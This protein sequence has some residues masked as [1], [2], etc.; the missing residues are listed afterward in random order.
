M[1]AE[2]RQRATDSGGRI[3][4]EAQKTEAEANGGALEEKSA[5]AGG[6]T[7]AE[8]KAC[9][10]RPSRKT[11]LLVTG[12]IALSLLL[13]LPVW[14]YSTRVY[15][16]P[17]PFAEISSFVHDVTARPISLSVH[18]DVILLLHPLPPT[19]QEEQQQQQQ[20]QS[21]PVPLDPPYPSS[22]LHA[23]AQAALS[24]LCSPHAVPDGSGFDSASHAA[25]CG[26]NH[27]MSVTLWSVKGA[28]CQSALATSPAATEMASPSSPQDWP[29]HLNWAQAMDAKA[30]LSESEFDTWLDGRIQGALFPSNSSGSSSPSAHPPPWDPVRRTQ[31]QGGR[32]VLLLLEPGG[33]R[34][35]GGRKEGEGRGEAGEEG[36]GGVCGSQWGSAVVVGKH[37][38]AWMMLPPAF[39]ASTSSHDDHGNLPL[40]LSPLAVHSLASL[41]VPPSH[42][43]HAHASGSSS[44]GRV[45]LPIGPDSAVR[46]S[47]SLLNADPSQWTFQWDFPSLQ[48]SLLH[49]LQTAFSPLLTL[50]FHSQVLYFAPMAAAARW[51]GQRRVHEMQVGD[52][53]FVVN[54]DTWHLHAS[55]PLMAHGRS[56][57]LHVV[58]YIPSLT[59]CP[60]TIASHAPTHGTTAN[61][62][63]GPAGVAPS[64]FISPGWGSVVIFNPLNCSAPSTP[65]SSSPSHS[66]PHVLS[67]SSFTPVL[68]LAIA[69]LRSLFGLSATPPAVCPHSPASPQADSSS[70]GS[71]SSK[72]EGVGARSLSAG[73]RGVAEWEVDTLLRQRLPA[74]EKTIAASLSSVSALV[75]SL[76]SMVVRDDISKFLYSALSSARA[77]R[78]AAAEGRY[79]D[80]QA[81]LREAKLAA[82]AA[83]FHPSM[84][85]GVFYPLEHHLAIYSPLFFP[86]GL[87]AAVAFI[88]ELRHFLQ[89]RQMVK[90]EG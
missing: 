28:A 13:W 44:S 90:V 1:S 31:Q 38:H 14:W 19:R 89:R 47:W 40:L 54:A 32:Y 66:S 56:K 24:A 42:A 26:S 17:L 64:G 16:A 60:L 78:E 71:R 75:Q 57:L 45:E 65:A 61:N 49:P 73:L 76:P 63:Q 8:G 20:Q 41:L 21:S 84:E 12:S 83:L 67:P 88:R 29:C 27:T 80:A 6:G 69:Q 9:G 4:A 35:G 52:L 18:V 72:G 39:S 36:E 37:R 81:A 2:I 22:Q 10:G 55:L 70:G 5:R 23:T 82:D 58:V 50:H 25:P 74:D 51:S 11:R 68:A 79:H 85:A 48:S 62:K 46:V 86:V 53:P 3:P 33:E 34:L 87:H 7:S 43:A 59:T 77:A 30:H 15:R